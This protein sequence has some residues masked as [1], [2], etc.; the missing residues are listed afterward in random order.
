MIL[1]RETKIKVD[2]FYSFSPSKQKDQLPPVSA[3][4]SVR[5]C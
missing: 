2:V 1:Q 5:W 4:A 3:L